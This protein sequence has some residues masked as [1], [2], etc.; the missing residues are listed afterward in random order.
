MA[1]YNVVAINAEGVIIGV[2][3]YDAQYDGHSQERRQ[4]AADAIAKRLHTVAP[5]I[6]SCRGAVSQDGKMWVTLYGNIQVGMV[7]TGIGSWGFP[8]R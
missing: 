7:Q 6:C 4:Q 3:P 2:E 1:A 5:A 8:G